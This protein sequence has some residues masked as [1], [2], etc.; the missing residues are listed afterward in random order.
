MKKTL[1]I[2]ITILFSTSAVFG[3]NNLVVI[4]MDG[5]PQQFIPIS[6][7]GPAISHALIGGKYATAT[8]ETDI[9][10]DKNGIVNG[11][12]IVTW[13]D[14]Q[15]SSTIT[16]EDGALVVT[17]VASTIDLLSGGLEENWLVDG[18]PYVPAVAIGLILEEV[19]ISDFAEWSA[20][21]LNYAAIA[22]LNNFPSWQMNS[23]I[24]QQLSSAP[25]LWCKA[26]IATIVGVLVTQLILGCGAAVA[27][28]AAGQ[29]PSIG[30]LAVPCG[31]VTVACSSAVLGGSLTAA[32]IIVYEAL[33]KYLWSNPFPF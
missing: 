31:F 28:C 26:Q 20:L 2:I 18:E 5:P 30:T 22:A 6:I 24:A 17:T 1:V 21:A 4:P 8:M 11:S 12:A 29:V 3:H 16:I 13:P 9:T 14:G 23:V 10:V 15:P 32:S 27:A 33:L 25:G 19:K 7:K